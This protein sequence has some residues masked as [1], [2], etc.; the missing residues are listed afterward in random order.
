MVLVEIRVGRMPI[1]LAKRIRSSRGRSKS[2][3]C[4]PGIDPREKK[5]EAIPSRSENQTDQQGA[6]DIQANDPKRIN[7]IPAAIETPAPPLRATRIGLLATLLVSMILL[8]V[9]VALRRKAG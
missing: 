9:F 8:V 2:I 4:G 7:P 5:D 6:R 1:I 3:G